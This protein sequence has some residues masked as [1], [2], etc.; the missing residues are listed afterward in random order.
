MQILEPTEQ[1]LI[2][3]PKSVGTPNTTTGK[4]SAKDLFKKSESSQSSKSFSDP[5]DPQKNT[6]SKIPHSLLFSEFNSLIIN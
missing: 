3:Q 6:T 1:K 4:P 2:R 5:A